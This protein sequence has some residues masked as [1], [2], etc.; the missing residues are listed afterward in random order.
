MLGSIF[1]GGNIL[2]LALNVLSMAFPALQ[3]FNALF[4]MLNQVVGQA[5]QQAIGQLLQQGLPGFI[6]E[7]LKGLIDQILGGNQKETSQG[8]QDAA[9]QQWGDTMQEL[10]NKLAAQFVQ[11]T[12]NEKEKQDE[13]Q[14][15]TNSGAGG[16]L[17]ALAKAFGKL[18]DAAAKELDEKGKNI[19]KDNPS[20]MIEYQALAQ[21][22]SLMMTTFTNAIKTIGEANTSTTRKSG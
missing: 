12:Q 10:T 4:N 5:L 19:N 7:A 20:D 17:R 18:A 6:G 3:M 22:F 13:A 15:G 2:G 11:D 8:A 14:G 1:G 21:E 16:W 9:Q